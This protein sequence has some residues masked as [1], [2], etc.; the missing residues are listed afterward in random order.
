MRFRIKP[1]APT[2]TSVHAGGP[3]PWGAGG[4]GWRHS[5]VAAP[6]TL[7]KKGFKKKIPRFLVP[8]KLHSLSSPTLTSIL[9]KKRTNQ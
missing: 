6:V 5:S 3:Q 8:T 4:T 7:N 1:T 2:C 9:G